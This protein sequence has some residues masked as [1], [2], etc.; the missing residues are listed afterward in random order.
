MLGSLTHLAL[1]RRTATVATL[2]A[3]SLAAAACDG[4]RRATDEAG[5]Q[6]DLTLATSSMSGYPA[7]T[8][9]MQPAVPPVPA[10]DVRR[11]GTAPVV[12]QLTDGTYRM[13]YLPAPAARPRGRP[14]RHPRPRSRR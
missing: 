11:D 7:T 10:A 4:R 5:L 2:V 3:A 8:A 1:H 6:H 14:R 13:A 12:V 9:A